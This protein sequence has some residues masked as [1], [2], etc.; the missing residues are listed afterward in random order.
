M[1]NNNNWRSPCT[2][3]THLWIRRPLRAI[4][5]E[6]WSISNLLRTTARSQC[7]CVCVVKET[8][9]RTLSFTSSLALC[10]SSII[11]LIN[12]ELTNST[13][14]W[15]GSSLFRCLLNGLVIMASRST[16]IFT[17][18][19]LLPNPIS[20]LLL[21]LTLLPPSAG[22]TKV[23]ERGRKREREVN[24]TPHGMNPVSFWDSFSFRLASFRLS[25]PAY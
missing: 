1:K 24:K 18:C 14:T 15:L 7:V 19:F 21:L 5:S 11:R 10:A 22:L 23:R 8:G 3:T 12:H 17:Y 20:L 16:R 9:Q 6:A 2:T 13:S 4:R 25:F